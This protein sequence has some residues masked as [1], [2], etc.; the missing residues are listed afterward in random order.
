MTEC[1]SISRAH[2]E[3]VARL[4]KNAWR[5]PNLADVVEQAREIRKPLFVGREPHAMRDI[6]R[7]ARYSLRMSSRV[8]ISSVQ[9]GDERR[10][11]RT[12][13]R[14]EVERWQRARSRSEPA[15][16]GTGRR[17][18]GAAS[19]GTEE[20]ERPRRDRHVRVSER[21][22]PGAREAEEFQ[23]TTLVSGHIV[24]GNE[25]FPASATVEDIR[26]KSTIASPIPAAAAPRAASRTHRRPS[27]TANAASP[28]A[29]GQ[30]R[31]D[32]QTTHRVYGRPRIDENRTATDDHG[33]ERVVRHRGEQ[34]RQR[35]NRH[36]RI[37]AN[38]DALPLGHCRH[39][40][41]SRDCPPRG[42]DPK[43]ESQKQRD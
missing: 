43:A 7:V 28:A 39:G 36:L 20:H 19:A 31:L 21:R 40:D 18:V 11:R 12:R 25:P 17:G 35:S 41:Q 5:K 14:A 27:S 16:S 2:L 4:L 8:V 26:I 29:A 37:W 24:S 10:K 38:S 9:R 32:V 30:D 3:S 13:W 23:P 34:N 15:G 42:S 22:P 33:H 1:C 6:V